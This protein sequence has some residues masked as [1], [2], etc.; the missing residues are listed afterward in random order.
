[1]KIRQ[2]RTPWL[3]RH[4][5]LNKDRSAT[6]VAGFHKHLA[7]SLGQ[8]SPDTIQEILSI[9]FPTATELSE[10]R[11]QYLLAEVVSK[12]PFEVKGID[13]DRTA[14]LKFHEAEA[15]CAATNSSV[16]RSSSSLDRLD[17]LSIIQMARAKIVHLLGPFNW[18]E[19]E[20]H[21]AFGPGATTARKR[22]E[23][24]AL[25]K[26]GMKPDVTLD[27]AL[28]SWCAVYRIPRWFEILTGS[29]P[30]G[31]AI[32]DLS[33]FPPELI[34][35]IVPG[36]K[37]VTVPKNAK[38]NRVI[39][40][41][42]CMNVFIQKGIGK[43][44]RR[45]LKRVGVNLDSQVLN[46]RLARRG[47]RYGRFATVD[48]SMASDTIS[49]E[50]I[51][52]LLPDDWA[53][54]LKQCR[55]PTGVLPD[56]S[57]VQYHKFSSM[58]NGFTFELESLIF[59]A[60]ARAVTDS[61][62]EFIRGKGIVTVYGD[63]LIVEAAL[64][65]RMLWAFERAGFTPNAKKSFFSGPFR[66]SCGKHYF[67]GSDVTPF[68]IKK[69]LRSIWNVFSMANNIR[70][71][72]RCSWGLDPRLKESYDNVVSLLPNWSRQFIPDGIGD[73]GLVRDWD[74]A[75]PRTAFAKEILTKKIIGRQ[76][77]SLAQ[78]FLPHTTK[79]HLSGANA[80]VKWFLMRREAR[81][82][83]P[84]GDVPRVSAD[85][86]VRHVFKVQQWPN[87]GPWL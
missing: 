71:W 65:D 79:Y 80:L 16:R 53:T 77:P 28:L 56:G 66:E 70:R 33:R 19:T 34:F 57:R 3:K 9:G 1:M 27:C 40:V 54:A 7:S 17:W 81:L 72:A 18:S 48:F 45:R 76:S 24:D 26:I 44:I 58:G 23:R 64:R 29:V 74:E 67:Q 68:Y 14:L 51:D 49:R 36:N 46:Q 63:D 15:Q 55:S 39:A 13:R 62:R 5:I 43:V 69:E 30:S 25:Y 60:L 85:V 75:M 4:K 47:S 11:D 35:N 31:N 61:S 8:S 83:Q 84:V 78:G 41:E 12:Y 22:R 38:T 59:W 10:F 20:G 50:L 32:D 86:A 21:F 73:V 6:F 2:K 52:L 82:E 87:W 42:P 37:V